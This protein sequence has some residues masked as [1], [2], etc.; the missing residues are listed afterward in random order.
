MVLDIFISHFDK[1]DLYE[2]DADKEDTANNYV[3]Q[4][5]RESDISHAGSDLSPHSPSR[6]R[7]VLHG[8][9]NHAFM[10]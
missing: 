6:P 9:N 4:D 5:P 1:M 10:V 3:T 2:G 8:E 7:S